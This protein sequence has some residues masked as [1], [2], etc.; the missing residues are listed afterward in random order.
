MN[1]HLI[2]EILSVC[3]GVMLTAATFKHNTKDFILLGAFGVF[4]VSSTLIHIVVSLTSTEIFLDINVPITWLLPS[5]MVP[6]WI[7]TLSISPKTLSPVLI[8]TGVIV[9]TFTLSTLLSLKIYYWHDIIVGRLLE[10]IPAILGIAAIGKV[11]NN[12]GK[13]K[14]L[15]LSLIFFI[16]SHIS[17]M[18]SITLYDSYFIMAHTLKLGWNL[19]LFLLLYN[20][21]ETILVDDIDSIVKSLKTTHKINYK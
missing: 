5:I 10:A 2:L 18:F 19:C 16:I 14:I 8:T 4:L 17:M 7:R 11:F 12:N 13:G 15:T 6:F 9:L 1:L 3:F 21:K 20:P